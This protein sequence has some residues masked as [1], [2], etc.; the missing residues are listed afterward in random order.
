MAF[1]KTLLVIGAGPGIG[2]SVT[3]LFASKRYNNVVLIAR[4]AEQLKLEEAA[5][6]EAVGSHVKVKSYAVDI[7]N[8]D[9]FTKALDDAET[10]FGRPECVFYNAARVLPSELLT[11]DVKEIEYDFKIT[12]SALYAV[13][14]REMPNLVRIAKAD[15]SAKP[16]VIVTSSA[17]PQQPIPQLFALSLVK[18]AQRNL[19]ESLSMTYGPQGVHIGLIN[20]GGPV[21]PTDTERSPSNIAAK[22]WEWFSDGESFEVLIGY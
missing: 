21:S 5:L 22:T 13:V 19:M 20:V 7:A 18:A 10:A 8:L 4:R 11:H 3:G 16:A 1:Q 2:R 6:T 9:A 15:S 17:L 14:Q 12:V